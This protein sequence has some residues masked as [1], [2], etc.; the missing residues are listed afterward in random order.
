LPGIGDGLEIKRTYNS[1]NQTAGLFGYGWSSIL[2]DLGCSLWN[3]SVAVEPGFSLPYSDS[4]ICKRRANDQTAYTEARGRRVESAGFLIARFFV[5]RG[6][7]STILLAINTFFL[8]LR[9]EYSASLIFKGN[10]GL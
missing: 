1:G 3:E 5:E 4:L 6:G 8:P 10:G 7:I 2:D 9:P